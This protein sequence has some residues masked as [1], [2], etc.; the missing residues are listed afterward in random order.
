LVQRLLDHVFGDLVCVI[1][2]TRAASAA[3]VNFGHHFD[4]LKV[5]FLK[6]VF[7]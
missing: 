4:C 3:A 1:W 5:G 6:D 7:Q 2:F